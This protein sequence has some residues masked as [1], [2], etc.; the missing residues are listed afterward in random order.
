[1]KAGKKYQIRPTGPSDIRRIEAG[2]LNFGSD[3]TIENNP[4][5]VGLDWIV[6]LDKKAEFIGRDAL[7][8]IKKEGVRR[9]LVGVEID[10]RSIEFN[11]T[12]WEVRS[13]REKVGHVTSAI[14]SPRL[15]KNIGYAM[16]PTDLSGLGAQITVVTP[17]GERSATVVRKPFIDPK[18]EIPKT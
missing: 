7:R 6:D 8:L 2:M 5:E 4:Y 11:Q 3:M 16:V 10:G 13:D 9:K 17:W 15:E 12:K 1:M 14:Y 18:K